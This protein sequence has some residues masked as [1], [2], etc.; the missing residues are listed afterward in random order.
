MTRRGWTGLAVLWCLGAAAGWTH[1]FGE[2]A[3]A[4]LE[5][6]KARAWRAEVDRLAAIQAKPPPSP[7]P[8]VSTDRLWNDVVALAYP[9]AADAARA[10][11]RKH[12]AHALQAMGYRPSL[13]AFSGGVNVLA[14]RRGTDPKAGAVL[15]GAHFDTVPGSPGA[16]DNASGV[17][18][19]L[20]LAR[21]FAKHPTVRTVRFAFFDGEERG[22]LGSR[23]YAASVARTA[24]L[25]GVVII[26]MVGFRCHEPGCQSAP[27]GLPADLVPKTGDFLAVVGDVEHPEL[28]VA[29]RHAAGPARPPVQVLPVV[30]K[31]A[32]LPDTR[33][34]DH[35]PFWDVGVGAVMVTDT[36]NLRTPHYHQPTDRPETLDRDFLTGAAQVIA[37][38]V[39][40]LASPPPA[41][42]PPPQR[43]SP[44]PSPPAPTPR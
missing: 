12:I 16:D 7:P 13:L 9:R 20:E 35:A 25:T 33:R 8:A 44:A 22:L 6:A 28:L 21:L 26:E 23:A 18:V 30:A 10:K 38:A 17:A 43:P 32:T 39:L 4:E 37:A 34:S 1:Y 2:R 5:V 29:F 11:A 14:E 40:E 41:T 27:S 31:G 19:A 36:A 15:V 3:A 42:G 24:D